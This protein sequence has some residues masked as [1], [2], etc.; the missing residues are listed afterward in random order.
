MID[1]NKSSKKITHDNK[2]GFCS[3]RHLLEVLM[4]ISSLFLIIFILIRDSS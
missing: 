3:S 2:F 1:E 4:N